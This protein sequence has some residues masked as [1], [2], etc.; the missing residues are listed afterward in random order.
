MTDKTLLDEIVN[1]SHAQQC[2]GDSSAENPCRAIVEYQNTLS[3]QKFQV[4]EPWSGQIEKAPILFLSSNP[5]I[6]GDEV[7]PTWDWSSREVHDYFNHRFGG[8]DKTWILD[9]T[10]SLRTDGT[11]SRATQFWAAVRQRAIELLQRDVIP[12]FDYALTEIV[13]CKSRN[14]SGVEQAQEQCVQTYLR[15][16]LELAKARVIVVLGARARQVI[17]REFEIPPEKLL[18]ESIEIGGNQRLFTFLPHPNARGERSFAKCL[19]NDELER[20]RAALRQNQ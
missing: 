18:S 17:Q 11:Y 13:H 6:G 14:E 16:I 12:G 8:G 15:R 4:P 2:L 3:L 1:C 10:K 5:S 19:Q 9:G 20:L 7:Y